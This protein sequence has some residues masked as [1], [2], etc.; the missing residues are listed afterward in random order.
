MILHFLLLVLPQIHPFDLGEEPLNS[1]ETMTLT[2]T[3]VKG[4][5]P[6]N[7]TWLFNDFPIDKSSSDGMSI[8]NVGK[9]NSMLNIDSVQAHNIGEY[10]CVASNKAGTGRYSTYLSVNG[11]LC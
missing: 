2:C 9:K 1:G 10:V 11:T 7:I 4:D 8:T 3:I 6:V 5:L